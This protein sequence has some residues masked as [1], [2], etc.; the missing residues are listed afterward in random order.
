MKARRLVDSGT[1]NWRKILIALIDPIWLGCNTYN[2]GTMELL[3][4]IY[5]V[6]GIVLPLLVLLGL[7]VASFLPKERRKR[8]LRRL[9]RAQ[10]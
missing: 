8:L 2:W 6:L 9:G 3:Q 4:N 10:F 7:V 1:V 5:A